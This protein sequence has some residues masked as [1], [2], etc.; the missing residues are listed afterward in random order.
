MTVES[1][2][3][4]LSSLVRPF[5][6]LRPVPEH[7]ADVAAPPYDVLNDDEARQYAQGKPWSFLHIS[8]P[9]IDCEVGISP[10]ADE[11]YLQSRKSLDKMRNETILVQDDTACY[12]I[13][14]LIM[15]EHIQTG[16]VVAASVDAY[17]QQFIKRHE[18][19][20]PKK[21]DDR[22]RQIDA[23]DSQTGPVIAT[24]RPDHSLRK[25]LEETTTSTSPA[26]D[27]TLEDGVR[28][29]IWVVKDS[30]HISRIS[31]H[32]G[33]DE[34]RINTL[35]I[36][37]GHHRSAAASRVAKLRN[38]NN[39]QHSGSEAYNY[40]LTVVFPSDELKVLDYNRLIVDLNKLEPTKFIE[41]V[42]KSFDVTPSEVAVSPTRY[43]EFGMYLKDQWY[44]LRV[45]DDLIPADDPVG[46]L[47]VSLLHENLIEPILN[48]T[49]SRRDP[50]IDFVG[51]IRGLGEL[52]RRVDSGEMSVAFS[53]YPT[54]LDELM[55]VADRGETMPTKSTWFE[56][57][58]ADGLV[59][60]MID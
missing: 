6:G 13:Y 32:F 15:G 59:S 52:Q 29:Q 4:A 17:D 14:R 54:D 31:S 30:D 58:L 28:H 51:G 5:P 25:I 57:K 45:K 48:I 22:V 35:Y 40:F 2:N 38:S 42:R 10:Y 41:T 26:S 11:V 56:P 43:D 60:H 8:K 9:V 27:V 36:A 46:S 16:V 39:P 44:C 34:D 47:A 53:M 12:Y 33:G 37:D 20:Q 49:D 23:L 18:F 24:H 21:E 50:R 55:A 7:A 19:T 1:D 3:P